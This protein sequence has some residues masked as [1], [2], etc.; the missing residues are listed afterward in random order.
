MAKKRETIASE[1]GPGRDK[2][3]RKRYIVF[4][5]EDGTPDL[6]NLPP[7]LQSAIGSAPAPAAPTGPPP[8]PPPPAF[9]S[10]LVKILLPVVS[11]LEAVFV[12]PRMGITVDQAT[13][14]LTPPPPLADAIAAAATKV[15]N[16]YFPEPGRWADEIALCAMIVTWQATAF[17]QMRR[18]AP[19]DVSPEPPRPPDRHESYQPPPPPPPPP[20]AD[21]APEPEPPQ[22]KTAPDGVPIFED[23]D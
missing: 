9:D 7:E 16:K 11:G 5:K 13:A 2:R 17:A 19:I 4:A 8:D 12:A 22:W 14:A 1:T 21:P 23:K 3:A 10:Q 18:M 6:D 20:P 15:L